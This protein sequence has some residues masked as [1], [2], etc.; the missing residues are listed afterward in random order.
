MDNV[1]DSYGAQWDVPEVPVGY[2]PDEWK[3]HRANHLMGQTAEIE[4]RQKALH[5][6][7]LWNATLYC[8]RQLTGFNWGVEPTDQDLVP[9]NL[10]TENLVLSIGDAMLSRANTSP[11][12]VKPT[13]RGADFTTYRMVKKLDRDSMASPMDST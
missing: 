5:E 12:R 13:P 1:F 10:I 2:Q 8:N 3:A 9:S 11:T 4:N 7:N 6:L